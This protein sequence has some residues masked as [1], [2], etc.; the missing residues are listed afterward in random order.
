MQLLHVMIIITVISLKSLLHTLA[1][2]SGCYYVGYMT[3]TQSGQ[4]NDIWA[5]GWWYSSSD[6]QYYITRWPVQAH[7]YGNLYVECNLRWSWHIQARQIELLVLIEPPTYKT[8][9]TLSYAESPH[10]FKALLVYLYDY[11]DK[12]YNL[13]HTLSCTVNFTSCVLLGIL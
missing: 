10:H 9:W 3:V 6:I 13:D 8:Y 7:N 5:L 2:V 12:L 1:Q 11:H 4:C